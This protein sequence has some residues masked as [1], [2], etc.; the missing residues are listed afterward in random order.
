[1]HS[2]CDSQKQTKQVTQL[3]YIFRNCTKQVYD[4][5]TSEYVEI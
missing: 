3:N 1:M 5:M 4:S 2:C